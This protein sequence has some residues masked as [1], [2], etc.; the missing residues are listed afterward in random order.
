MIVAG[1]SVYTPEGLRELDIHIRGG[2]IEAMT[3][4]DRR[5]SGAGPESQTGRADVAVDATGLWVLPGAIDAHVHGRDPGFPEKEDFAS[6]TAAAAM[7]AGA[8]AGVR[9]QAWRLDRAA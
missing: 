7:V 9:Y 8:V 5:L 2:R 1:G 3:P 6:L 4:W